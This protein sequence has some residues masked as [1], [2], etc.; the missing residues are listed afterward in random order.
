MFFS[1]KDH[2]FEMRVFDLKTQE[3]E[4]D[5]VEVSNEAVAAFWLSLK[6]VGMKNWKKVVVK[7]VKYTPESF[8]RHVL[9]L[10]LSSFDDDGVR[11]YAK[12]KMRTVL[13]ELQRKFIII[14]IGVLG[15]SSKENP[16]HVLIRIMSKFPLPPT[17]D[18][19][20][21][22]NAQSLL[23]MLEEGKKPFVEIYHGQHP[24]ILIT[25]LL[26]YLM[27]SRRKGAAFC[28]E[29]GNNVRSHIF[30]EGLSLIIDGFDTEFIKYRLNLQQR[31]II[32]DT[33]Q[34]MNMSIEMAL[35]LRNNV[36]YNDMFKV[37]KSFLI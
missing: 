1:K 11:R 19:K 6:K 5:I 28:L 4:L 9:E 32:Y 25:N 12:Y 17:S 24:E 30:K 10:I 27:L 13:R 33:E 14:S 23:K 37:A 3:K 18:L 31:E 21:Y 8:I 35:A 15:I 20:I 36:S 26:F 7:E 22:R 34:K 29:Y 2:S 16:Q